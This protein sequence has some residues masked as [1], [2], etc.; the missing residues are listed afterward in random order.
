MLTTCFP[1]GSLE[2]WICA[3]Q[4]ALNVTKAQYKTWALS[5]LTGFP[6]QRHCTPALCCYGKT[7]LFVTSQGKDRDKKACTERSL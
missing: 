6:G 1:S 2:F 3:Q 4:T 5:L 7:V